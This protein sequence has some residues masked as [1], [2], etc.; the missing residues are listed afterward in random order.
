MDGLDKLVV[1]DPAESS[2]CGTNRQIQYFGWMGL[3]NAGDADQVRRNG[4]LSRGYTKNPKK[5]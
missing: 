5:K 3:T 2:F 1:N 4:Y